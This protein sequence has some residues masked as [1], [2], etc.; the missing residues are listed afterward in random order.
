MKTELILV[1]HGETE[2]NIKGELH[3]DKDSQSLNKTGKSQVKKTAKRLLEYNPSVI[4]SSNETRAVESAEI[5]ADI[6]KLPLQKI[7]GMQERNWGEFS[8]K[9]WPEVAKVLDKMTLEERYSYVP[10]SGESWESSFNRMKDAIDKVILE[11]KGETIVVV[12]HGGT[13]RI[14]MPYLLNR[15]K[16][17]SFKH[18]PANASITVF[19]H[20]DGKFKQ[21]L[22][23]D[24]SH[25]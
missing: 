25:L 1:R 18:D 12:T 22:I 14:I 5:I 3:R 8:G 2:T 20:I 16:E 21:L 17:E 4:Y 19:E 10:P 11:N 23:D 24:T 7:S 13:I 15:P 6:C 9:S